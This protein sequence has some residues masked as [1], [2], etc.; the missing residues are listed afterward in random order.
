MSVKFI[1]SL[2]EYALCTFLNKDAYLEETN[3]FFFYFASFFSKVDTIELSV[4][5][6][7]FKD[8]TCHRIRVDLQNAQ[9]YNMGRDKIF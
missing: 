2:V 6:H 9:K 3:I 7:L 5:C 8:K 1:A 4:Y